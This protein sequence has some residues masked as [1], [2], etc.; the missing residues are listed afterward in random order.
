MYKLADPL[1][2]NRIFLKTTAFLDLWSY[3]SALWLPWK[4]HFNLKIENFLNYCN[5]P[6]DYI[7]LDHV[8]D[9]QERL[10]GNSQLE[11]SNCQMCQSDRCCIGAYAS[12]L[13]QQPGTI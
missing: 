6:P 10:P 2:F 13:P 7:Q 8:Y 12:P 9:V 4:Q 3:I 11:L 5:D 1:I